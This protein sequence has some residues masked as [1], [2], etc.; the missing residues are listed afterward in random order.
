MFDLARFGL[1]GMTECGAALRKLSEG[2]V[3]SVRCWA[4]EASFRPANG[5]FAVILFAKV[6]IA[7]ESVDLFEALALCTKIALLPFEGQAVFAG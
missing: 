6:Q 5:L 1:R 7:R 2:A 4:S 3:D